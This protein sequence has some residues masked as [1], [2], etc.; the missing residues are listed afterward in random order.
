MDEIS[1]YLYLGN[2]DDAFHINERTPNIEAVVNVRYDHPVSEKMRGRKH[3]W[4]PMHDGP[5]N[6]PIYFDAVIG[7]IRRLQDA[8]TRTLVHCAIGM[9]RS[10]AVVIGYLAQHAG[11]KFE[12]AHAHVQTVRPIVH[13]DACLLMSLK[14]YLMTFR[15][16][17]NG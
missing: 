9:S 7:A 16:R 8:G 5:G 14:T 4:F 15:G 10:P 12:E 1:P 11:M 6:D 13:I 2:S 17:K 3:F